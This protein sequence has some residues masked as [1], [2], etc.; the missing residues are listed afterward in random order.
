[1]TDTVSLSDLALAAY[2][3]R[4]LHYARG[5]DRTPPPEYEAAVALSRRYRDVF[6]PGGEVPAADLAVHPSTFEDALAAARDG[7]A[8]W[9]ALVDPARTAVSL[10]GKDVHGQVAKVLGDPLAPSIVSPGAPPPE[11]VWKPQSVKAVGAAKA[12]AWE[13][14]TAVDRA[15][16]EYPRHGVIRSVSLSTRNKAAYRRTIRAVRSM[17][18]PPPRVDDDS[19][20]E[21][22]RFAEQCGVRTRSLKTLLTG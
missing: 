11:G 1:V 19:K 9:P 7:L 21:P 14:E 12:L 22:C 5:T 17:D 2:C 18:G 16:V 13:R 6:G 20:C 3:P 8:A 4:K 15:Y 10:A